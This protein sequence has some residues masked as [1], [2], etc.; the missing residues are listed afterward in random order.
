MNM[1]AQMSGY[2]D[3]HHYRR[4]GVVISRTNSIRLAPPLMA[5]M[6]RRR[7]PSGIWRQ[8][9]VIG[10]MVAAPRPAQ[11]MEIACTDVYWP[12]RC[13]FSML[14]AEEVRGHATVRRLLMIMAVR[15]DWARRRFNP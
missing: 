3:K 14:S 7:E 1:P 5:V 9:F 2:R 15:A 6:S 8:T 13:L 12:P 10:Q 4:D 11:G